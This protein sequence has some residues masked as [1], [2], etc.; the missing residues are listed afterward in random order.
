M[1]AN[2]RI[3]QLS[4]TN[5]DS[6]SVQVRFL[7]IEKGS[8][9]YID[10]VIKRPTP[11]DDNEEAVLAWDL[12]DQLA[13]G[14]IALEME[15]RL[16]NNVKHCKTSRELWLKLKETY[17]SKSVQTQTELL[18]QLTQFRMK[19]EDDMDDFLESYA[20]SVYKIC[21]LGLIDMDALFSFF[22]LNA[23]PASYDT[24]RQILS[25]ENALPHMETIK[26][27]L[28]QE[29]RLRK[30]RG[31]KK[32]EEDALLSRNHRGPKN[33]NRWKNNREGETNR[34]PTNR[35]PTN[36]EPSKKEPIIKC[37]H[38]GRIGHKGPDCRQ[39]NPKPQ[40]MA[41]TEIMEET[42]LGCGDSS[43][44]EAWCLDS[45]ATSH[46]TAHREKIQDLQE[47]SQVLSL[48]SKEKTRI[49][50]QG[51]AEVVLDDGS[52][53]LRATMN[54]TLFV[55]DL[56]TNLMSVSK[57]TDHG[58]TVTFKKDAA[59]VMSSNDDVLAIAKR[60]NNLYIVR[61]IGEQS[62]RASVET[63]TKSQ[64]TL[65]HEKLGHLNPASMKLMLNNK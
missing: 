9:P 6:W 56:R 53:G 27:R 41:A 2:Y 54:N 47:R 21:E 30:N 39:K 65:W 25:S 51:A 34:E 22:L 52:T 13:M 33:N 20:N 14:H 4:K 23:L 64:T 18:S 46:M 36:R 44:P 32:P 16:M 35:E 10:N 63:K 29:A 11:T 40:A 62:K 57:L 5:Y 42:A 26:S 50:G 61:E 19:E 48:A 37:C 60:K 15:S 17:Q 3:A 43:H 58:L 49:E 24:T 8:W 55:P 12:R 38:C 59:Y 28:S 45:G 7:L 31:S 1:S